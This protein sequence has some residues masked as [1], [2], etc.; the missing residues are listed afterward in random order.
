MQVPLP[1]LS[2]HFSWDSPRSLWLHPLQGGLS[3]LGVQQPQMG[4]SPPFHQFLPWA[5]LQK[6][7]EVRGQSQPG[8]FRSQGLASLDSG[9]GSGLGLSWGQGSEEPRLSKGQMSK[10]SRVYLSQGPGWSSC[11][12]IIT[13]AGL[14]HMPC[15]SELGKGIPP[16]SSSPTLGS[17]FGPKPPP[18]PCRCT[19][20]NSR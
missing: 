18:A 5:P 6:E 3:C 4:L 7:S 9:I 1:D 8:L 16:G 15:W 19:L 14:A 2:L 20:K 10:A 17:W 12:E 11:S 13:K